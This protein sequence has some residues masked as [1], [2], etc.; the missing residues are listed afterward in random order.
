MQH[1]HHIYHI[2]P[3]MMLVIMYCVIVSNSID[4]FQLQIIVVDRIN[5]N[6]KPYNDVNKETKSENNVK[7]TINIYCNYLKLFLLML[8]SDVV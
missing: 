3:L 7:Y 1:E 4:N 6:K 8:C 2:F 5:D